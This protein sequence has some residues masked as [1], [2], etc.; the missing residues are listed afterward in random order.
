MSVPNPVLSRSPVRFLERAGLITPSRGAVPRFF[1]RQNPV[2]RL[3]VVA[4]IL[5]P[6]MFIDWEGIP[7][8]DAGPSQPWPPTLAGL[9]PPN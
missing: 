7:Q 5:D 8:S 9:I 6:A 2:S 4:P 1:P 3:E